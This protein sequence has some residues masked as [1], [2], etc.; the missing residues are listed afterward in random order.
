MLQ[1]VI[2]MGWVSPH[3]LKVVYSKHSCLHR[4]RNLKKR[5]AELEA[6]WEKSAVKDHGLSKEAYVRLSLRAE[7]V[8]EHLKFMEDV[9]TKGWGLALFGKLKRKLK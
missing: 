8:G 1:S 2:V 9:E 5:I 6:E 4:G 3:A 7:I